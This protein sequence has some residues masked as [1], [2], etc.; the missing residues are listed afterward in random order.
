MNG[1]M[2]IVGQLIVAF[3]RVNIVFTVVNCNYNNKNCC[4][5]KKLFC[6]HVSILT[7]T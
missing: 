6:S 2:D 1:T 3:K 5:A 4:V 7:V